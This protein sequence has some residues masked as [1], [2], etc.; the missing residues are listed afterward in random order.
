MSKL[1][2]QFAVHEN[3]EKKFQPALS[4]SHL[5]V[6]WRSHGDEEDTENYLEHS[7]I[8]TLS[9]EYLERSCTFTNALSALMLGKTCRSCYRRRIRSGTGMHS[10]KRAPAAFKEL[11][12]HAVRV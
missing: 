10:T 1:E 9:V 2:A 11:R 4:S 8:V 7:L 5:I 3:K 6:A 12:K